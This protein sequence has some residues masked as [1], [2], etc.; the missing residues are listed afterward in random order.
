[1]SPIVSPSLEERLDRNPIITASRDSG[2]LKSV[3]DKGLDPNFRHVVMKY[4]LADATVALSTLTDDSSDQK[5]SFFAKESYSGGHLAELTTLFCEVVGCED[6]P[7]RLSTYISDI[8]NWT[9]LWFLNAFGEFA[10]EVSNLDPFEFYHNRSPK[11][12]LTN[13]QYKQAGGFGKVFGAKALFGQIEKS[14][15]NLTTISDFTVH[16]TRP[17][18]AKAVRE[19][20]DFP[21]ERSAGGLL[22]IERTRHNNILERSAEVYGEHLDLSLSFDALRT[23]G[24]LLYG[25]SALG[26]FGYVVKDPEA[27]EVGKAVFYASFPSLWQKLKLWGA[28][29]PLETV[30]YLLEQASLRIN[31]YQMYQA[32]T[33]ELESKIDAV[34]RHTAELQRLQDEAELREAELDAAKAKAREAEATVRADLAEERIGFIEGQRKK[35]RQF[36][37]KILDYMN[38][39]IQAR[40][41]ADRHAMKN[42]L[43]VL[44]EAT[45]QMSLQPLSTFYSQLETAESTQELEKLVKDFRLQLAEKPKDRNKPHPFLLTGNKK[46]FLTYVEMVC[47]LF[48]RKIRGGEEHWDARWDLLTEG[49][50]YGPAPLP[51]QKDSRERFPIAEYKT[52]MIRNWYQGIRAQ[53]PDLE[54]HIDHDMFLSSISNRINISSSLTHISMELE[55]EAK[56]SK[57]INFGLVDLKELADSAVGVACADKGR[58][59]QYNSSYGNLSEDDVKVEG[60]TSIIGDVLRDIIYNCIDAGSL[61]VDVHF[62]KVNEI[63]SDLEACVTLTPKQKEKLSEEGIFYLRVRDAAG[64]G[65]FPLVGPE[66]KEHKGA[67]PMT[68]YLMTGSIPQEYLPEEENANF[69]TKDGGKGGD[70]TIMLYEM[71]DFM[72]AKAFYDLTDKGTDLYLV[73]TKRELL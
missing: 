44:S 4:S 54:S 57:D 12:M 47:K 9:S 25:A 66:G 45:S 41:G 5:L 43:G 27:A 23:E 72:E 68:Q 22:R 15:R 48:P 52:R 33:L 58:Q 2:L 11:L 73:F 6:E 51:G 36:N 32:Q 16:E 59:V 40:K 20:I 19:R 10:R 30:E 7:W 29:R 49:K 17:K 53:F 3:I 71:L 35:E 64:E 28:R 26:D 18:E 24:V 39:L 65:K 69:T 63:S 62:G 13:R 34:T 31:G 14:S 56:D 38:R 55:R 37:R 8:D 70:G 61:T 21:K 46:E 67:L 42:K 50:L 1:M 60:I